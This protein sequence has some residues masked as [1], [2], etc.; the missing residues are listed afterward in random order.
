MSVINL[1][2]IYLNLQELTKDQ[3]KEEQK[4][5]GIYFDDD[6]N[7]LQHLKDTKEV[8]LVLQP[9]SILL[10]LFSELKMHL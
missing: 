6:Y 9:V 4:K 7:Y 3:Q 10:I 5:Y 2:V 8:T 1:N